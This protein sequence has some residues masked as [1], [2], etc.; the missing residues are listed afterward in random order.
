MQVIDDEIRKLKP[1]KPTDFAKMIASMCGREMVGEPTEAKFLEEILNE[2]TG[3]NFE[4][5]N[6]VLLVLNQE[7]VSSRF[8]DFFFRGGKHGGPVS[9]ESLKRGIEK[10]RGFALL[11]YGNFRH[12]YQRLSSVRT[13]AEDFQRAVKRHC[14]PSSAEMRHKFLGRPPKTLRIHPIDKSLTWLTGY[15]SAGKYSQDSATFFAIVLRLGGARTRDIMEWRRKELFQDQFQKHEV[16]NERE[17][18]RKFGKPAFAELTLRVHRETKSFLRQVQE[19]AKA[20]N[21]NEK[22]WLPTLPH[23]FEVLQNYRTWTQNARSK[24]ERN[25]DAYLSWDYMDV[26]VATSMRERWEYEATYDFLEQVFKRDSQLR[27]LKLRYFDPTQ[28]YMTNRI[29]KGLVEALMLRRAACTLYLA[30]ETDTL[31]KD[32]ELAST[33]A[34]GKTVIA[35]V[36]QIRSAELH[37]RR[38]AK[39]PLDFIAKRWL[40][41][42]AEGFFAL[43][44]CQKD[45]EGRFG[46]ALNARNQ[47]NGGGF[48]VLANDLLRKFQLI[49]AE[50][51]FNLIER[52]EREMKTR[53]GK[54]F[55][56][57]CLILAILERRYFD[58][59]ADTLRETHPLAIQVHLSDGVA[60][61]V[62][63]V[64]SAKQCARL[65][66]GRLTNSL[67]FS[68]RH[69]YKMTELREK[70]SNCP[71]RVV[72]EDRKVTSSFWN[73]YL[74]P[75]AERWI[76]EVKI[77]K[78]Y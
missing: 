26:Y 58:K 19:K 48:P 76:I 30:Q 13:T 42:Q 69:S 1:S 33:L 39:M 36:P 29:D 34:Q 65:L 59:R 61:G 66:Y 22:R 9:L 2:T 44:D 43:P 18:T 20:P 70:I 74:T 62:L 77:C 68:I 54:T 55:T 32:S 5:F 40:Q 8:F 35:Y 57:M 21:L 3:L 4:Q 12:A 47:P 14:A 41:L 51:K 7:R 15:L 49:T 52:E 46:T 73:F 67:L 23:V 60:H 27:R 16:E 53:L 37:A 63:V 72:T 11:E 64:R 6:E 25:T 24:G 31:V 56:D 71:Y 75:D 78:G 45:L 10:F 50:R 28:S 17:F 38:I